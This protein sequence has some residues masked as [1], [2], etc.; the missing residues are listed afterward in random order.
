MYTDENPLY[1]FQVFTRKFV[2]FSTLWQFLS[3]TRKYAQ[4][5][6]YTQEQRTIFALKEVTAYDVENVLTVNVPT[7]SYYGINVG[8]NF[9]IR[10][11]VF[12][13]MRGKNRN[14]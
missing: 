12:S 13:S 8:G 1:I 7:V 14:F 4:Y 5:W 6:L 2:P 11:N 9:Y 3:F 10:C